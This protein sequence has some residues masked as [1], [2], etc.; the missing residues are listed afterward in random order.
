MHID[1]D[2][3]RKLLPLSDIDYS[4][5]PL[6][7]YLF[8]VLNLHKNENVANW[9]ISNFINP[10]IDIML[11][12]HD[13]ENYYV[14]YEEFFRQELWYSC[15]FIS[16]SSLKKEL[17]Q[18]QYKKD[19]SSFVRYAVDRGYYVYVDINRHFIK[20]YNCKENFVHNILVYG[21][22]P[23]KQVINIAD[24]FKNNQFSRE[25]CSFKE[26][27]DA[28]KEMKLV[29][30]SEFF[31]EINLFKFKGENNYNFNIAEVYNKLLDFFNGTNLIDKYYFSYFAYEYRNTNNLYFGLNYYDALKIILKEGKELSP[32]TLQLLVVHKNIM[33]ERLL[34]LKNIGIASDELINENNNILN[35]T[36][37]IRNILV[38]E[39]IK[40]NSY[41]I[42][43]KEK[44]KELNK[45][46][47]NL[48]YRDYLFTKE[49]L[50]NFKRNISS[51]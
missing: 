40:N 22:D 41:L 44:C 45:L 30:A 15:P 20:N 43:D 5:S 26:L 27:N 17:L 51:L 3:N 25:I 8:G 34:K 13:F 31:E 12:D 6:L 46:I 32:K 36:I 19:F 7:N 42:Q 2:I 18:E 4:H 24:Y 38:K 50:G 33:N 47:S 14:V 35:D 28:F 9:V 49:L 10:C 21:Y 16:S 29:K 1:N 39:H 48:H 11:P 37:I 23:D